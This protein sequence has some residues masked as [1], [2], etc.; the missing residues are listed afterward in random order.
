VGLIADT[1]VGEFLTEIPPAVFTALD[2]CDLI[3]HAGD[4]SVM[5]VLTDLERIAPV[6]AV[7]GD[8]DRDAEALPT[9]LVAVVAGQRIG[10]IHGSLG[11]VPDA[12]VAVAQ[13]GAGR[14][15]PWR[16]GYHRRLIARL[17]NLDALVYG[18]WHF[19]VIARVGAVT[20]V[21]PGAVCPEGSLHGGQPPGMG[22]TG[23][24]DRI[25]RRFRAVMPPENMLPSVAIL[26][27]GTSGVR[28]RLVTLDTS[29]G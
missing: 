7:R 23:V 3:L 19:P 1:H 5:S 20:V 6:R 2:G 13:A 27:V 14:P 4:L 28:P 21:N 18:H 12:A 25:V 16:A 26:E 29:E 9:S 15:L 22:M 11:R 8:H 24:A 10:V 17:G